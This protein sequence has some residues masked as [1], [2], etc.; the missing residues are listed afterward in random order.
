MLISGQYFLAVRLLAI[1]TSLSSSQVRTHVLIKNCWPPLSRTRSIKSV[2]LSFCT[3]LWENNN[4]HPERCSLSFSSQIF[5]LV[6]GLVPITVLCMKT[7]LAVNLCKMGTTVA[8]INLL[9]YISL[10]FKHRKLP[11]L[12]PR[13]AFLF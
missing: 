1:G 10:G 13:L 11:N 7:W 3:G 9:A 2:F 12:L 4:N 5:L 6:T 8:H